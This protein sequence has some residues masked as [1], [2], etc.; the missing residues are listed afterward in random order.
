[1][2]SLRA[3]Q[4]RSRLQPV[5]LDLK[6]HRPYQWI[7]RG[8]LTLS[9]ATTVGLPLWHLQVLSRQ[10]AGL[11]GFGSAA[12][13]FDAT[14]AP[15]FLGMPGAI[16]IFG[17]EFVDPLAL[18]G[19][20]LARGPSWALLWAG[21]PALVLVLVLG[22]FFCGWL[23]P[24]LPILAASNVARW[25]LAR[26]GLRPPDAAVPRVTSRLILVGVLAGSAV[27][28][29]QLLPLIY[30]P[31]ILGREAFR[32]VFFGSLSLGTLVVGGAFLFDTFVSRA[33]FCRSLCP[34]GAMFSLLSAA[35]VVRVVREPEQCTDCTVCDVVCNLGQRPMTD[36]LDSGCE[37]CGKCVAACPTDALKLA[38]VFPTA[39][40]G[41]RR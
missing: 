20:L 34:G 19:V 30:P 8:V 35:S 24:Y 4:A 10:S 41:P 40:P 39:R 29:V 7:R 16:S 23:C 1:M 25:V 26:A 11:A 3:A 37:R 36:Q 33:G 28:G 32:L 5:D 27:L 2:P 21:L 14:T 15:P 22:R 12:G 17:L 9:V 6:H 18:L 31:S 38:L 13:A